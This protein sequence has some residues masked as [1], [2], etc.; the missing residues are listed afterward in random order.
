MPVSEVAPAKL[1][2]IP[3]I[4]VFACL[5]AFVSVVE[6]LPIATELAID[7]LAFLP[8]ATAFALLALALLPIA[9]VSLPFVTALAPIARALLPCAFVLSVAL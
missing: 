5:V 6:S 9:I 7:A 3:L 8:N 1:Y 2:V 4:V